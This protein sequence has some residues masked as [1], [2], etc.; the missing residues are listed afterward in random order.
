[1]EKVKFMIGYETETEASRI[2]LILHDTQDGCSCNSILLPETFD[3]IYAYDHDY[4]VRNRHNTDLN[5][6]NQKR[7]CSGQRSQG[8]KTNKIKTRRS[9]LASNLFQVDQENLTKII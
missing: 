1:M 3:Q 2:G 6:I 4:R 7:I 9:I 8:L 5:G